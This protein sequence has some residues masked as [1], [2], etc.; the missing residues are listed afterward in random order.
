MVGVIC[1]AEC[2]NFIANRSKRC[3]EIW[4]DLCAYTTLSLGDLRLKEE[5]VKGYRKYFRFL[6]A[7]KFLTSADHI[8][9]IRLKVLGR[10]LYPSR[11]G[12][13]WDSYCT[14]REAHKTQWP[15]DTTSSATKQ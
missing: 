3:A 4:T 14:N 5:R 12:D 11:D 8:E 7:Y 2:Y 9:S 13:E 6:E 1:C 15:R 10:E